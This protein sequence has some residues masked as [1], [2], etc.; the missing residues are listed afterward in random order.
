L[1]HARAG[2]TG[3]GTAN[4]IVPLGDT[5]LELVA[6]VDQAEAKRSAFGSW[7]AAASGAVA[8]PLGWAVRTDAL[9]EVAS[10]LE[11]SVATGSLHQI[12]ARADLDKVG[13]W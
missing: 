2:A 9:D 11:L 6:V 7:V 10:R 8:R 4:R 13:T 12:E 3:W 5:Y 1:P